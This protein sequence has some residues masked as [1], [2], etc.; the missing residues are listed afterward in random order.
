MSR[1]TPYVSSHDVKEYEMVAV[2]ALH[3]V[4]STFISHGMPDDG[5]PTPGRIPQ[6]HHHTLPHA[7]DLSIPSHPISPPITSPPVPGSFE[8]LFSFLH[9]LRKRSRP[10][11]LPVGETISHP[12]TQNSQLP[13]S[14]KTVKNHSRNEPMSMSSGRQR[15]GDSD[16]GA[17]TSQE[18]ASRKFSHAPPPTTVPPRTNVEQKDPSQGIR[19]RLFCPPNVCGASQETITG[20]AGHQVAPASRYGRNPMEEITNSQRPKLTVPLPPPPPPPPP[21]NR[22]PPVDSSVIS[23]PATLHI[24][25]PVSPQTYSPMRPTAT[26]NDSSGSAPASSGDAVSSS[27][28]QSMLNLDDLGPDF[29]DLFVRPPPVLI[30]PTP[31]TPKLLTPSG[32]S[33]ETWDTTS[34]A[35][36]YFGDN[37]SSI[38]PTYNTSRSS[39]RGGSEVS[40]TSRLGSDTS[41]PRSARTT[42]VLESSPSTTKFDDSNLNFLEFDFDETH[43]KP[44]EG[45]QSIGRVSFLDL[46]ESPVPPA[47]R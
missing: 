11:T 5:A 25:L 37:N 23:S 22:R 31:T 39:R 16:V 40:F 36:E 38:S 10:K 30:P 43:V 44:R 28:E 32:P 34:F 12:A 45:K 21:P 1:Q 35:R 24:Q 8:P 13:T 7:L 46:S 29:G 33:P 14:S 17:A 2:H 6:H 3:R 27:G 41:F 26:S 19:S 18:L 20:P 15:G 9:R 4:E 47:S 42:P